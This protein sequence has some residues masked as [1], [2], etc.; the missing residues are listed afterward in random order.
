MLVTTVGIYGD[1]CQLL[2]TP[3]ST[4]SVPVVTTVS[5]YPADVCCSVYLLLVYT[6]CTYGNYCPLGSTVR[7]LLRM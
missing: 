6:V 2:M 7:Y 5:T 3:A 1:Y 4:L